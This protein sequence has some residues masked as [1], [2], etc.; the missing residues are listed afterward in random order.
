MSL[1]WQSIGSLARTARSATAAGSPS[2]SERLAALPRLAG[3]VWSG[4]YPGMSRQRLLL[5]LGAVAYVVSPAD[6]LP[7]GLLG[8]FGL[9]DDAAAIAWLA[10]VPVGETQAF[11]DWERHLDVVHS[12]VV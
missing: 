11:L 10:A 8:P 12:T 7:E 1:R 6:L 5:V 9:A 4:D 3:R 2:W